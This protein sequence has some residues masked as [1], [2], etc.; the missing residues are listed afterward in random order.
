MLCCAYCCTSAMPTRIPW[1][2]YAKYVEPS[3][4]PLVGW[5]ALL[6]VAF[7][8]ANLLGP[9]LAAK[10]GLRQDSISGEPGWA[11]SLLVLGVGLGFALGIVALAWAEKS[12]FDLQFKRW[13]AFQRS[14]IAAVGAGM[15][16]SGSSTGSPGAG[17]GT[18]SAGGRRSAGASPQ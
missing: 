7:N 14:L 15:S 2:R 10:V 18:R 3:P 17:H 12:T 16:H 11:E 13:D 5:A 6:H 9:V 1:H 8:A 4:W